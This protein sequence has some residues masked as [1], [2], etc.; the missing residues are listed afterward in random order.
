M[1][2][3]SLT[4]LGFL[5][6]RNLFLIGLGKFLAMTMAVTTFPSVLSFLAG[7]RLNVFQ[8]S[9]LASIS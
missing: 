9:H 8:A 4:S 1:V 5:D 2:S 6:F 7:T 3:F